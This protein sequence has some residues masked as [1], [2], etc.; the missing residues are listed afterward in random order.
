MNIL[1]PIDGSNSALMTLYWASGF[2]NPKTTQIYLLYV[3]PMVPIT[4]EIPMM[5]AEYDTTDAKRYLAQAQ[6]IMEKAGFTVKEA[7][8]LIGEPGKTICQYAEETGINQIIIGS[9]GYGPVSELLFGSVSKYVFKHAK[10]PVVLLNNSNPP[11][12]AI[13]H[14]EEVTLAEV[15]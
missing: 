4:S 10:H 14:P 1:I 12:I 3:I 5:N 2:L 15:E 11:S 6:D 8:Y 9:H 13:S 7:Q